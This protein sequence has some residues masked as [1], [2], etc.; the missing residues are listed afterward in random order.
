VR[1]NVTTEIRR[2]MVS[3]PHGY[4]MLEDDGDGLKPLGPN[5][6]D[7][8][9]SSLCDAIAKTPFHKHVPVRISALVAA[10]AK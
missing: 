3:L 10:A 2:G 8:T 5:V 4:G 1:V 6:N 9:D 7:L